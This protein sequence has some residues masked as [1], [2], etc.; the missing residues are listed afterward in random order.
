M[1]GGF[2]AIFLWKLG[3]FCGNAAYVMVLQRIGTI[4]LPVHLREM[5]ER[6]CERVSQWLGSCLKFSISR[7]SGRVITR[8]PF[9]MMSTCGWKS[10]LPRSFLSKRRVMKWP[11]L[12]VVPVAPTMPGVRVKEMGLSVIG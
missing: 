10:A 11:I 6:W 2:K 9:A 5:H 8:T 3:T 1:S 12:A 4:A 7:R